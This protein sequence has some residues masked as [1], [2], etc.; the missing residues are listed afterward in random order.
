MNATCCRC[1]A[2]RCCKLRR[3]IASCKARDGTAIQLKL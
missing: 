3:F 1:N 2:H